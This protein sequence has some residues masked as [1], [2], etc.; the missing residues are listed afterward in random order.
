MVEYER[1]FNELSRYAMEFISTEANRA[2]RFKQGLRPV[3]REKLVALK[4]QDYGDIM[5]RTAL[6]ERD[7]K[8]IHRRQSSA[9]G[10]LI[11]TGARESG[12]QRA[13]PSPSP[14]SGT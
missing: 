10:G 9:R 8:D 11:W 7:I 3:I 14:D 1:R 6:M 4:I 2:K 13:E 12:V 5:D